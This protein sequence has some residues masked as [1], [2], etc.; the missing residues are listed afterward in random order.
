MKG[1]KSYFL[2]MYLVGDLPV[3]WRADDTESQASLEDQEW[4]LFPITVHW[5]P[6]FI[7]KNN[8]QTTPFLEDFW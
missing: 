7:L 8:K 4:C 6:L 3:N 1:D 5:M 2:C